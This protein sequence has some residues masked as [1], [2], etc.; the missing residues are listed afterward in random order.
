MFGPRNASTLRNSI[1]VSHRM[2]ARIAEK[3][4]VEPSGRHSLCGRPQRLK[5]FIG[6]LKMFTNPPVR[7]YL[8]ALT[9]TIRDRCFATKPTASWT[10]RA[11]RQNSLVGRYTVGWILEGK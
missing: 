10:P 9:D 4:T 11:A 5:G 7:L 8:Q 1:V 3:E 6:I 2:E